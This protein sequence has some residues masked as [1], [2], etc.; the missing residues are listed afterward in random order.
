MQD[1]G[2]I[3]SHSLVDPS[4]RESEQLRVQRRNKPTSTILKIGPEIFVSLKTDAIEDQYKIGQEIGEGDDSILQIVYTNHI[5]SF[6]KVILAT[7][8]AT[9]IVR[10]MKTINKKFVH[11]NDEEKFFA[12]VNTLRDLDHPNIL[13]LYELYQDEQNYYLIME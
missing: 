2:G 3:V 4:L 13:K 10:A 6:G 7:H 9:G 12:E 8:K 5:G 11:N 1:V